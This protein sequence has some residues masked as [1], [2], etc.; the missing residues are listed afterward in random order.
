MEDRIDKIISGDHLQHFHFSDPSILKCGRVLVSSYLWP[1]I[2]LEFDLE[3]ME[4]QLIR[5]NSGFGLGEYDGEE[6][7]ILRTVR[8]LEIDQHTISLEKAIQL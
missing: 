2:F 7:E 6:K 4:A 5:D 1:R 3:K 8:I